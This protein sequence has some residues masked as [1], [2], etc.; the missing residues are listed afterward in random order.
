[1]KKFSRL[2]RIDKLKE[3][4][5]DIETDIAGHATGFIATYDSGQE[6][7]VIGYLAEYDALPGP[8]MRVVIILLELLVYLRVQH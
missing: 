5:F 7:P 6:G 8:V 2:E 4:D 1:M 3:N